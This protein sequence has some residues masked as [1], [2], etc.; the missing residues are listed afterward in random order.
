MENEALKFINKINN[1]TYLLDGEWLPFPPWA[2]YFLELG[3]AVS[4]YER[5]NNNRLIAAITVPIRDYAASLLASG[6]IIPRVGIV[7]Q[8]LQSHIKK[9]EKLPIGTSV[10]FFWNNRQMKGIYKGTKNSEMGQHFNITFQKG[11]EI[12]I[13]Y[14]DAYKISV[15]D[16]QV[17]HLPNTQKG[18]HIPTPSPIMKELLDPSLLRKLGYKLDDGRVLDG[19]I[20]D[21][22]RVKGAQF[23][24]TGLSHRTYVLPATGKYNQQFASKINNFI[25]V[26]DN[27]L[28]FIKWRNFF[29]NSNWFVILDKTDRNFDLAIKEVN[30]EY[31]QNRVEKNVK[32][33]IPNAPAGIDLMLFEVTV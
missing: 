29:R 19:Q 31:I 8:D 20:G 32:L 17:E 25:T 5:K 14:E 12:Y 16:K 13:R 27:S 33:P 6:I 11:T 21:F 9:I 1:F 10:K 2:R 24:S 3:A 15:S 7:S 18:R 4:C 22:V 23:Q 28:G 26:F 30:E